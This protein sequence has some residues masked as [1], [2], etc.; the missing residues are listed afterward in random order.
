LYIIETHTHADHISS[1]KQIKAVTPHSVVVRHPNAPSKTADVYVHDG[2]TLFLGDKK[3]TILH[4][5]GHTNESVSI[6]N[7]KEVF[8]GDTL[9]LGGT[10]RTDFQ[11]GD[12]EKLY[13]SI[14]EKIA[15]LPNTTLIRPGHNYER[16]NVDSLVNQ[17]H[18]NERIRLCRDAFILYMNDYHP[19]KPELFDISIEKN[20]L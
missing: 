4:T 2:E 7:G 14:H 10:G 13:D 18:T 20:S 9:L 3:L 1:A 17:L 19:K 16:K 15:Q 8:T 5:P 6:Y 12:S 11:V